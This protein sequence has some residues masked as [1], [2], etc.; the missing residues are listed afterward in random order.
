MSP[1]S[2]NNPFHLKSRG[3]GDA[4]SDRQI[5]RSMLDLMYSTTQTRA[6][7]NRGDK[8]VCSRLA[9]PGVQDRYDIG[10]RCRYLNLI[11]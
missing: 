6:K 9:P 2:V 11:H 1:K 7:K 8:S 5:H 4:A 10:R 3:N